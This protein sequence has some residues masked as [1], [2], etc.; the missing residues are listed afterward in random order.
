MVRVTN[1]T[2][3]YA[4]S[5]E[6]KIP[7]IHHLIGRTMSWIVSQEV[8]DDEQNID[9]E[10]F[11]GSGIITGVEEYHFTLQLEDGSTYVH[12]YNDFDIIHEEDIDHAFTSFWW[13]IRK[14]DNLRK[15]EDT[16]V[17]YDIYALVD[18]RSHRIRYVGMSYWAE[19][20]YLQHINS[21]SN[22][23]HKDQW[24][25]ELKDNNLVPQMVILETV[26]G[27]RNAEIREREL[28]Q[29][30]IKQGEHLTNIDRLEVVK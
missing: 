11:S 1:G 14:R 30:Y 16:S 28:I 6:V 22:N 2:I 17:K 15:R 23:P 12:G 26:G 20:R 29:Q 5:E 7:S 19:N 9:F 25:D 3:R 24:I 4:K 21:H 10:Y 8:W 18:P 13:A 27:K